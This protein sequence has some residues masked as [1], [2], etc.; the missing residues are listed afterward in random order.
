MKNKQIIAI[1]LSV[2]F[3]FTSCSNALHDALP[4][5][6]P[7]ISP[8][9]SAMYRYLGVM[10]DQEKGGQINSEIMNDELYSRYSTEVQTLMNLMLNLNLTMF[11][12]LRFENLKIP[13]WYFERLPRHWIW[14]IL[15]TEWH[16]AK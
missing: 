1:M 6:R 9:M 16:F 15:R 10:Y 12:R 13:E 11:R 8:D 5:N 4:K 3:I 2:A 7:Y 14:N